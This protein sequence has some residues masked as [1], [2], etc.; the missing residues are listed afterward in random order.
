[1]KNETMMVRVSVP[2]PTTAEM[3]TYLIKNG[4]QPQRKCQRSALTVTVYEQ[5]PWSRVE[6]PENVNAEAD[7]D[8]LVWAFRN[9]GMGRECFVDVRDRTFLCEEV[10]EALGK[11]AV[12]VAMEM[13]N[14]V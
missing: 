4:F 5:S 6:W 2:A 8:V 7:K 3:V 11:T 13:K 10:A 9:P 1:M 12:Q 14:A